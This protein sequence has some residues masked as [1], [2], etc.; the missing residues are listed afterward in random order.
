M[1]SLHIPYTLTLVA[2]T[3]RDP[4][5]NTIKRG[6]IAEFDATLDVEYT[7]HEDWEIVSVTFEQTRW[8][9]EFEVSAESDPDLWK[10]IQRSFEYD[11]KDLGDKVREFIVEDHAEYGDDR[12][13]YLRDMQMGR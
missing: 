5:L 13:D 4:I 12:G 3:G 9:D 10:L 2:N 7:D 8:N 11:W 6:F 1:P